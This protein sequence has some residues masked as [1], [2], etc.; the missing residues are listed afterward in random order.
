[1]SFDIF[2]VVAART[3]ASASISRKEMGRG[4]GERERQGTEEHPRAPKAMARPQRLD[5]K[6]GGG[7]G[8]VGGVVGW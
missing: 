3:A 7:R 8:E 5:R 2:P 6:G 4:R 1:M